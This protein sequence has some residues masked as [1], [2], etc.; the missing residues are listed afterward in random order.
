[1]I[2]Q[3][4]RRDQAWKFMP[5]MFALV[6]ALCVVRAATHVEWLFLAAYVY[7]SAVW[8]VG[9]N[10]RV[11]FFEAALPVSGRQLFLARML[12][13]FLLLWLPALGGIGALLGM[14][15]AHG[16]GDAWAVAALAGLITLGIVSGSAVRIEEF[17]VPNW[18]MTVV[19][20]AVAGVGLPAMYSVP[21]AVVTAGSVAV[22]AVVFGLVWRGIPQA[23]QCA[24]VE[25]RGNRARAAAGGH[26]WKWAPVARSIFSFRGAGLL[27]GLASFGITAFWWFA[28][29]LAAGFVTQARQRSGWVLALPMRRRTLLL[30]VLAA[31]LLALTGGV[32]ADIELPI[33]LFNMRVV[34]VEKTTPP[35][36]LVS[37]RF[38]QIAPAG[39]APTVRSPWG[40]SCRPETIN[41]RLFDFYNPYTVCPGRSAS[42]LNWQF[43]RAAIEIYG[44]RLDAAQHPDPGDEGYRP[45]PPGSRLWAVYLGTITC[46]FLLWLCILELAS[47]HR[48]QPK[49][50]WAAPVA[51]TL[52]FVAISAA[53]YLDLAHNGK[54]GSGPLTAGMLDLVLRR[55]AGALPA[56]A[57]LAALASSVPV[58]V[59]YLLFDKLAAGS[60]MV[61][62][63]ADAMDRFRRLT[64]GSTAIS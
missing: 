45:V 19:W 28:P 24:P 18:L 32:I 10:R 38:W 58:L 5:A 59:L 14:E 34:R 60:E 33:S 7:L 31:P 37:Y 48:L 25:A 50:R 1:M 49:A 17:A 13:M 47:W 2:Y 26:D 20:S 40:E 27:C 6:V 42:F 63:K 43:G 41:L 53:L 21:H 54:S 55:M 29:M 56:N 30:A 15:G 16:A 4:M 11:T 51:P 12:S 36:L 57:A 61:V 9:P 62:L 46:L 23:F 39:Q 52:L 35:N 64:G 44:R 8:V 22:S 3:F